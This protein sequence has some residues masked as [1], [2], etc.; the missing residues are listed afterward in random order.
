ML[1]KCSAVETNA[2]AE[3][4]QRRGLLFGACSAV[5]CSVGRAGLS[6]GKIRGEAYYSLHAVQ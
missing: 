3:A 5:V 1:L 2:E 6:R 4:E